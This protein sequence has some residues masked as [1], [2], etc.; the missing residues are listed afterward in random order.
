MTQTY[1]AAKRFKS[2]STDFCVYL[3]QIFGLTHPDFCQTQNFG[4]SLG[5]IAEKIPK[6]QH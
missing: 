3:S 2:N 6:K 1:L 4:E 5:G